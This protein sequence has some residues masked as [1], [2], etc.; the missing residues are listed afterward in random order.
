[1]IEYRKRDPEQMFDQYANMPRAHQ[2]QSFMMLRGMKLNHFEV[3]QHGAYVPAQVPNRIP[4]PAF[5]WRA[6]TRCGGELQRQRRTSNSWV[7]FHR[8]LCIRNSERSPG[9][10]LSKLRSR[11]EKAAVEPNVVAAA[12]SSMAF[13]SRSMASSSDR[14]SNVTDMFGAEPNTSL[15]EAAAHPPSACSAIAIEGKLPSTCAS[16]R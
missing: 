11:S 16:C 6:F 15:D 4:Q 1:M 9:I 5:R 3:R 12:S 13:C 2:E 10:R 8:S 7:S 14:S